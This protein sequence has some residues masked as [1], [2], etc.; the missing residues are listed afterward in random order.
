[1]KN[2]RDAANLFLFVLGKRDRFIGCTGYP[3]C[4]YTRAMEEEARRSIARCRISR[5]PTMS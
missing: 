4:S 5:R 1:M 2:A 3:D